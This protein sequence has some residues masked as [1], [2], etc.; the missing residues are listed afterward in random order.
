[1]PALAAPQRELEEGA[2]ARPAIVAA[3]D[4]TQA[5]ARIG[6]WRASD[7]EFRTWLSG[8]IAPAAALRRLALR[9]W[10]AGNPGLAS[11]MLA[12]SASLD[13][14]RPEVWRELGF[15]LQ[16]SG[17]TRQAVLA[18]R[19]SLALDPSLARG[20]L[21]LGLAANQVGETELAEQAFGA[22]LER[23]PG[24]SEAAFGLG[25]IAFD[26]RRYGPAAQAFR[27]ALALGAEAPLARIGLGQSLFFLGEFAAAAAELRVAVAGGFVETSILRRAALCAYLAAACERDLERADRDYLEIAGSDAEDLEKVAF[28]AFRILVG[29]D[30]CDEALALAGARMPGR[31]V[32]PVQRY[33]VAAAAG[34]PCVRAPDEFVVAHFDAFAEE[35]DRQLVDVLGYRAPQQLLELVEAA[36]RP[37]PR[38]LDLGCGTGLA[39]PLLRAGRE[40]LVGVD[41]SPRMLDKANGRQ[42]YDELVEAEFVGY[43]RQTQERFDLLFAA[44]ALIYIGDLSTV[45]ACAARVTSPGALF[46][47][48]IET[49]EAGPFELKP[50]GRFAHELARLSELAGPWFRVRSFRRAALRREGLSEARGALVVME[51]RGGASRA[52]IPTPAPAILAA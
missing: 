17:E 38:V 45:F 16:A 41:L 32:D 8:G 13:P 2:V 19:R 28:S 26:Q 36:G 23:D 29:Y 25:L 3:V 34:A 48:N 1:M 18:L 5:A 49:T 43:L 44:D 51:R 24:L 11:V 20:W 27:R 46:A 4:P 42:V 52:Q 22:A 37:L 40:R 14:E 39:G 9:R 35:F 47:F 30:R 7:D 6:I 31:E 50:S 12:T 15:T 10:S 21:A 33:L